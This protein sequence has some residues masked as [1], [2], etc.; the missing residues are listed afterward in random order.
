MWN[1]AEFLEGTTATVAAQSRAEMIKQV[2]CWRAHLMKIVSLV[3]VDNSRV[4]I[5]ASTD[6]SVRYTYLYT[7]FM[8]Y[9]KFLGILLY[10]DNK[11]FN[12]VWYP[13]RGHYVGYFGQHRIWLIDP[14]PS[15]PSSPVLPYDI[16]EGPLNP[17]NPRSGKKKPQTKKYEYPLVFDA[18]RCGVCGL[19]YFSSHF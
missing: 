8:M 1:V 4:V 19:I 13:Q 14:N 18:D 6:G 2:V 16:T 17:V 9:S 10:T 15:I 7:M 3:F 11:F 12:R 5:S